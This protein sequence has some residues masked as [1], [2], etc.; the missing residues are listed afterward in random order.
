MLI[1]NAYC[2][3][4]LF[5]YWPKPLNSDFFQ[6]FIEFK[7]T[8]AANVMLGQFFILNINRVSWIL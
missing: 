8:L 3:S 5:G 7:I 1:L 6:I 2:W 4:H